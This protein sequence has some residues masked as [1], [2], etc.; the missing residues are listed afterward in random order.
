MKNKMNVLQPML[1]NFDSFTRRFN[2][3]NWG[4]IESLFTEF[5]IG[6]DDANETE[7]HMIIRAEKVFGFPVPTYKHKWQHYRHLQTNALLK[8]T[9]CVYDVDEL[10]ENDFETG[11]YFLKWSPSS[12]GRHVTYCH[13]LEIAHN[14][15]NA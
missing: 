9:R 6:R 10:H 1:Y 14:A 4:Y 3:N 5:G 11:G 15:Y 13:T 12:C 2:R 8:I 7:P